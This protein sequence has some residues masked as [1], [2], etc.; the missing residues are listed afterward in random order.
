LVTLYI[1]LAES[2]TKVKVSP[3]LKIVSSTLLI[4]V[5]QIVEPHPSKKI[6]FGLYSVIVS[7]NDATAKPEL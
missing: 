2:G 1:V 6:L 7:A 3:V 5:T 4:S